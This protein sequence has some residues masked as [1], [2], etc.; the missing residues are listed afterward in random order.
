MQI[1]TILLDIIPLINLFILVFILFQ[2]VKFQKMETNK[3]KEIVQNVVPLEQA[4]AVV[5]S[6]NEA[7]KKVKNTQIL[8]ENVPWDIPKDVKLAVE[9]GDTNTPP[10]FE[11]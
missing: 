2:I 1:A 5:S 6:P 9:G 10:D 3:S 4:D 7:S 11:V 8:D